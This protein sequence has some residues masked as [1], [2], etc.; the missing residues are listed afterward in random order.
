MGKP[1]AILTG[2]GR[3]IGRAVAQALDRIDYR[4]VLVSRTAT[5][6][7]QTAKLLTAENLMVQADVSVPDD[8]DALVHS[9]VARFG[10]IDAVIHCAG[11]APVRSIAEMSAEEWRSDR[12]QFVRGILPLP[13]GL[14]AFR[15]TGGRSRGACFI[16]G[17][18]GPVSR[19]C[20]LRGR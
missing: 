1:V 12:H 14:A 5:E 9:A 20:G 10:R 16:P 3:G 13:C 6:L 18:A 11:V 2:A 17:G 8:V 4:L 19:V 7:E 15:E